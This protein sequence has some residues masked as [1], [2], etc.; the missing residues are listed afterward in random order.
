LTPKRRGRSNKLLVVSASQL[1][2]PEWAWL[3]ESAQP[4]A[5]VAYTLFVYKLNAKQSLR[6]NRLMTAMMW[7]ARIFFPSS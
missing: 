6:N 1:M 2:R 4:E 3:R 5:R 7:C